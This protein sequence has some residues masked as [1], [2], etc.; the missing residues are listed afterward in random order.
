MECYEEV[1]SRKRTKQF[2]CWLTFD[3][4]V[5]RERPSPNFRNRESLL[6]KKVVSCIPVI[7][8]ISKTNANNSGQYCFRKTINFHNMRWPYFIQGEW[9]THFCLI[10]TTENTF[11][12]HWMIICRICNNFHLPLVI[13]FTG[14]I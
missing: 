13:S 5:Q 14:I 7:D 2:L 1:I 4:I 3:V 9:K 10:K 11:F 12:S 6:R 8:I